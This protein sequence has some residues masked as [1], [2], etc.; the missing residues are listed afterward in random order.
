MSKKILVTGGLG[1]IGSHTAVAVA[2]AGYEPVLVDDLSNSYIWILERIE[3]ILGRKVK[4]HQFDVKDGNALDRCFQAEGGFAGVIHFAAFKAV[5]ESVKEPL[6]YYENNIGTTTQLLKAMSR[7]EKPVMV[8]S[9]SCTVYGSPAKIPVTE[10]APRL[11]AFSPY[12]RTKQICED[13]IEDWAKSCPSSRSVLLRYFN[14]I[15]A[16]E[17]ALIGELP[18]GVPNNLVPFVAQTAAGIRKE[19]TI[20]GDTYKTPDGTC[21]RDYI[22]V[23]DLAKAHVRAIEYASNEQPAGTVS[24]FNVGTGEGNSVLEV[25]KTFMSVTGQNVA[26]KIGPIR[27]GDVPAIYADPSRANAVMKWRAELTLEDALRDSWRWQ[28]TLKASDIA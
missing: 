7:G 10:E 25:V 28:Q 15:G 12:G 14:P 8:F 1:Y 22:H 9:S 19:L 20:F 16:H 13:V 27:E 23:V 24:T 26:Y 3:K 2:E 21:V 11:P 4:F 18:R 6:K 17:S 5:G